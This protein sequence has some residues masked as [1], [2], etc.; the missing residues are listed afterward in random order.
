MELKPGDMRKTVLIPLAV[1]LT[2]DKEVDHHAY[3]TA[4]DTLQ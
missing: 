3:D 2:Y 4:V 1:K